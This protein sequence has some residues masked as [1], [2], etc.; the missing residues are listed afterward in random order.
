MT[1]SE[2]TQLIDFFANQLVLV[3]TATNMVY[4]VYYGMSSDIIEIRFLV[5]Q[6]VLTH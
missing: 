2:R 3:N 5:S 6:A 4:L 1:T